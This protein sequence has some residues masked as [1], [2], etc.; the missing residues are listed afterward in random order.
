M[1][2]IVFVVRRARHPRILNL[3]NSLLP[4]RPPSVGKVATP[5][6]DWVTLDRDRGTDLADLKR[7][8]ALG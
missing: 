6:I 3:R 5:S 2:W 4:T 7:S 1:N 8:L